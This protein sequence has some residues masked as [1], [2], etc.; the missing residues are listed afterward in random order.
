MRSRGRGKEPTPRSVSLTADAEAIQILPSPLGR[1]QFSPSAPRRAAP[2]VKSSS[3]AVDLSI[4]SP[5]LPLPRA[6]NSWS[7]RGNPMFT[8]LRRGHA[9]HNRAKGQTKSP[10]RKTEFV[11]VTRDDCPQKVS[12]VFTHEHIQII[13]RMP[14][15]VNI[16]KI[17]GQGFFL[18]KSR[19]RVSHFR[20]LY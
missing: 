12:G 20:R 9:T 17:P 16:S 11:P 5:C 7:H 2:T 1:R 3:P 18:L 13:L 14:S 15:C 4:S 8:Q 10:P 19:V 6:K